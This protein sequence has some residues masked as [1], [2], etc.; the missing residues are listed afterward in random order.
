MLWTW[1][2]GMPIP[3]ELDLHHFAHAFPI[4]SVLQYHHLPS[5]SAV[6]SDGTILNPK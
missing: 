5:D 2:Q 4:T 6:P 3:T 1:A